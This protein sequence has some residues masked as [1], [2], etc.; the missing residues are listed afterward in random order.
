MWDD[1]YTRTRE[2]N[3]NLF[4]L[5]S[6]TV[7][8]SSVVVKFVEIVVSITVIITIVIITFVSVTRVALYYIQGLHR[9]PVHLPEP[10]S[11][12]GLQNP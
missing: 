7:L 2:R 3:T 12:D 9:H 10:N 5:N 8:V 4:T 1:A 11:L 6:N